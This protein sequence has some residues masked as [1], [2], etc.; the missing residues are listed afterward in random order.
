MRLALLLGIA[1]ALSCGGSS[2]PPAPPSRAV[3]WK[4]PA[5]LLPEDLDFVVRVD[6]RRLR[7]SPLYE[8]LRRGIASAGLAA[9]GEALRALIDGGTA[10]Y[11]G[12][13]ILSDGFMGDGV[14]AVDTADTSASGAALLSA[15]IRTRRAADPSVAIFEAA[16]PTERSSPALVVVLAGR[17]VVVATAA[18]AD[19]V[20]RVLDA[21]SDAN[22]LDPPARGLLSFAGAPRESAA[23][24]LG[25]AQRRH[26][27]RIL[28]GLVRFSGSMDFAEGISAEADLVYVSEERARAAAEAAHALLDLTALLGGAF[29]PLR[30]ST[31]IAASG[32]GVQL[33][34]TVPLELAAKLGGGEGRGKGAGT[35]TGAGAGG[36]R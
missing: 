28:D 12:G 15:P 25:G 1:V 6:Y 3:E 34:T 17:G 32:E 33:R 10:V 4:E 30:E 14:L 2:R 11:F 5:E 9:K 20:L 23:G 7:A 21:G 13:R 27:R 26:L 8:V 24:E 29:R 22:R 16:G 18:E 35:G 31:R 19:A 36:A